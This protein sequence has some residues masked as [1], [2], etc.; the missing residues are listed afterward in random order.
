MLGSLTDKTNKLRCSLWL[1]TSPKGDG[2]SAYRAALQDFHRHGGYN[3]P[4]LASAFRT[5]FKRP[6]HHA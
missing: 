2:F 5:V 3:I 6:A 1:I 4:V